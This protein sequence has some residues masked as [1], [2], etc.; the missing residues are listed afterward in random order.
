M[1]LPAIPLLSRLEPPALERLLVRSVTRPVTRGSVLFLTGEARER[2]YFVLDGSFLL[3][4]RDPSGTESVIGFAAHGRLLDEAGT[5]DGEPHTCDG[6][7]AADA[8]VLS[9]EAGTL[10]R[11]LDRS[12]AATKELVRQLEARLDWMTTAATERVTCRVEG[13]VAGRLLDLADSLGA[14]RNGAIELHLPVQQE[15]LGLLAGTTRESACKTMRLL[16]KRGI[17][18]YRG[19]KLRILRP[20][21]LDYL[22]CGGRAAGSSPSADGEDRRRSRQ[23][24]GT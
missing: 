24:S 20:D 2:A 5:A 14:T 19:R 6:I 7:A 22:R 3:I 18:D 12:A 10:R 13:R 4:A 21:A 9:V 1:A 17:L 15:Q 16:K 23:R 8:I 11:E